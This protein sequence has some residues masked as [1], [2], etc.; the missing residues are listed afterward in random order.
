MGLWAVGRGLSNG[1][2]G[3]RAGWATSSS[4]RR[5]PRRSHSN[6]ASPLDGGPSP[7]LAAAVAAGAYVLARRVVLLGASAVPLVRLR[8][9]AAA[10]TPV[11]LVKG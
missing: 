4:R 5:L 1:I 11:D 7:S 9:A 2:V 6:T 3:S 8:E 10:P